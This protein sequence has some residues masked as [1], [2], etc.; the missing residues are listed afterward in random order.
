MK[1]LKFLLMAALFAVAFTSCK[2]GDTGPAGQDGNANVQTHISY[3]TVYNQSGTSWTSTIFVQDITQDIV[4]YG[5]VLVYGK[6][7]DSYFAFPM[8][9]PRTENYATTYNYTYEM[10]IVRLEVT[11][12]DM[13]LPD[14][15]EFTQ[16]KVVTIAGNGLIQ[17][18][19]YTDYEQVKEAY[20]LE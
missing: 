10:G 3:N 11:D 7:E 2:K 16:I 8:T 15:P 13:V 5:A 19:D 18:V 4:D 6:L 9:F 1:N 20:H 14:Y 17:G 12:T